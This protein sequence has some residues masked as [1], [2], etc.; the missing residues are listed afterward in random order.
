MTENLLPR[1]STPSCDGV[2]SH[3]QTASSLIRKT[4]QSPYE[5]KEKPRAAAGT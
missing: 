3:K 5:E 2:T 1:D 4:L